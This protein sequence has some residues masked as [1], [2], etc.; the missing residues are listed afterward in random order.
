MS[1]QLYS[2]N[3]SNFVL[4]TLLNNTNILYNSAYPLSKEDF[5]P[6]LS[7]KI[8]YITICQLADKGCSVI[9]AKELVTY[10]EGGYEEQLNALKEDISDGNIIGYIDT[11][12]ALDNNNSYEYWYQEVR[13]RSLLRKYRDNGFNISK[14]WD[15][16]KSEEKNIAKLNNFTLKDIV[17]YFDTIQ[18]ELRQ[19]FI[20]EENVRRIQAGE[21]YEE[22]KEAFKSTPYFGAC[23]ES[24]YQTTLFRGWLKGQVIMN[25]A[26]SGMGKAQ[27][28]DTIIPTPIGNRKLGDIKVGDYVFDRYG[29]PTKVLGVYPQGVIDNYKVI[30]KDGRTTYCNNEH[31]WNVLIDGHREKVMKTVDTNYIISWLNN[32]TKNGKRTST[33][34]IPS[35]NAVEYPEKIFKIDPYV[36]GSFIGNGCCKEG[37][38][39]LS[40]SD[41]EQ[42]QEV[43]RLINAKPIKR[44]KDNYSW[45]FKILDGFDKEVR[46]DNLNMFNNYYHTKQFFNGYE[47]NIMCYSY[48][49]SIPNEY[50]Y[51]SIKQRYNLLQGLFDTDG[52]ISYRDGRYAVSYSTT[53]IKLKDDILEILYSLGYSASVK[54]DKR[55]KY[56]NGI[57]YT[58]NVLVDNEEKSKFFRISRKKNIA[59]EAS[60]YKNKKI[61]SRHYDRLPIVSVEK[62]PNPCEM[63]CIYVDNEEHL[64]LTNDY[65]VT[66]NTVRAV[67]ELC[68]VCATEL[69]DNDKQAFVPNLNRQGSG[70]Y[71][72]TEM[73]LDLEL[74]PCFLAYISNVPR[75]DIM[76]GVYKNEEEEKR[77]DKAIQILR[78]SQIFLVDDPN[79]TLRSIEDNIK[80]Y[81]EQYNVQYMVFDY[82]QDNGVIGKEMKSTNEII[83]RDTIILNMASRFKVF[84]RQYDIGIYTMSQLNGQEKTADI[85]DE[86]CLSGGRAVK[87]KLDAGC[88]SL[89]PRKKEMK[90]TEGLLLHWQSENQFGDF[91]ENLIKPNTVL[92]NYKVRFGKYGVGIK[93]YQYLDKSTGRCIDMFCTDSYDNPI[94]IDKT[95]IGA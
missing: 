36:F 80:F 57:C 3:A 2:I 1:E 31:L 38:L 90:F 48:E 6:N 89:Q 19:N 44:R 88:I 55:T 79:F 52:S 24:P 58:I 66:H 51:S 83:A 5:K 54:E 71:I 10:L 78:D 72:N 86:A 39:T 22:I 25:S 59:I 28:I 23:M 84:A 12:K 15:E 33:I 81:K 73:D 32:H 43:A 94:N 11:L 4:S 27:P 60:I 7:H 17:G 87:N 45:N 42:V 8:I 56:T 34:Y 70:L 16:D 92:H 93:I 37:E 95:I 18:T 35:S 50:K 82:L 67:G 62:M 46:I 29:K 77:V 63:V 9:D 68:K 41:N 61:K 20:I 75:S 30:F 13:K 40:S 69:W 53:S 49:K 85:I 65:I 21:N 76:D 26:P 47:D 91:G 14:F 74:T 64:Y